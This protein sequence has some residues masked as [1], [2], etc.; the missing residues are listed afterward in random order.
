MASNSRRRWWS[1]SDA[2]ADG[3]REDSESTH[4]GCL[5]SKTATNLGIFFRRLPDSPGL[6]LPARVLRRVVVTDRF[7]IGDGTG[8]GA[9]V[10]LLRLHLVQS[11]SYRLVDDNRHAHAA[12]FAEAVEA[13]TCRLP[14]PLNH[15][16]FRPHPLRVRISARERINAK[17]ENRWRYPHPPLPSR[18]QPE[19]QNTYQS[20]SYLTAS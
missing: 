18:K 17:A 6:S 20:M 3:G 10:I 8:T 7:G 13:H 12:F 16:N 4:A 19:T 1:Q 15:R 9:A 11:E 14:H 2:I 5:G